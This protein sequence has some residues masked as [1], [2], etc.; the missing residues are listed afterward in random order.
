[1]KVLALLL[2][3]IS[4]AH[5]APDAP[6]AECVTAAYKLNSAIQNPNLQGLALDPYVREVMQACRLPEKVYKET[7]QNDEPGLAYYSYKASC[8]LNQIG[9]R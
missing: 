3:T 1:M 2:A 6:S 8:V 5:A 7:C 4:Y 9:A